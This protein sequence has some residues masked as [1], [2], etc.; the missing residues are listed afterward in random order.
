MLTGQHTAR[1]QQ[2]PSMPGC[3]FFPRP[4]C[5]ICQE[6]YPGRPGKQSGSFL[7]IIVAF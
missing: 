6:A 5:T 3:P 7:E 4:A 2:R 1:R